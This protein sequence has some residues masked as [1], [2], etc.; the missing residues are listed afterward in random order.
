MESNGIQRNET[1]SNGIHRKF[2]MAESSPKFSSSFQQIPTE[3]NGLRRI[4]TEFI[5]IFRRNEVL[6]GATHSNGMNK[7]RGSPT[8]SAELQI[9][10]RW[11]ALDY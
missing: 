5:P 9:G 4:P 6:H 3:S 1:E 11:N 10:L 8:E 2:D 7:F